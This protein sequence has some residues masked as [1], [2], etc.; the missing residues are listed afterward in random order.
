MEDRALAP[1]QR[2]WVAQRFSVAIKDIP[3]MGNNSSREAAAYI[4]PEPA[5]SEA[6]G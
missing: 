2:F 3:L 5:L 1:D 4:S 6:E